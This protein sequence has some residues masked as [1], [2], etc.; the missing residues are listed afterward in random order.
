MGEIGER[1][2]SGSGGEKRVSG[3]TG[4]KKCLIRK[5]DTLKLLRNVNSDSLSAMTK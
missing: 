3:G 5:N 2:R 1:E 4:K